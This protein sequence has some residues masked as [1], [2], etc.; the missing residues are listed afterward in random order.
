MAEIWLLNFNLTQTT[1]IF[2]SLTQTKIHTLTHTH[3][4]THTHTCTSNRQPVSDPLSFVCRRVVVGSSQSRPSSPRRLCP[5]SVLQPAGRLLSWPGPAA[6]IDCL[7]QHYTDS[8]TWLA[9]TCRQRATC[10]IFFF[11]FFLS[12]NFSVAL[13][14]YSSFFSNHKAALYCDIQ[15]PSGFTVYFQLIKSSRIWWLLSLYFILLPA[16]WWWNGSEIAHQLFFF[17]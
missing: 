1:H 2:L 12:A 3:T 7:L 4:H 16:E 17:F 5:G 9:C 14:S 15:P 6:A 11:F 8:H 13:F 10:Q